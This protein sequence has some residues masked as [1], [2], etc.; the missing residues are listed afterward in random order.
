MLIRIITLVACCA[1]SS[2]VMAQTAADCITEYEV[3]KAQ[4]ELASPGAQLNCVKEKNIINLDTEGDLPTGCTVGWD[5][6]HL[7][8][9]ASGAQEGSCSMMLRGQDIVEGQSLQEGCGTA[10]FSID[11][12]ANEA[13]KWRN[14]LRTECG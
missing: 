14:Y 7:E 10:G 6:W 11:L 12:P 4:F 1:L 3:L 8:A 9:K 2:S 13:A 5:H